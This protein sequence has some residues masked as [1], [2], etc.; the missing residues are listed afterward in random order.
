[1]LPKVCAWIRPTVITFTKIYWIL[2]MHSNVIIK[3]VSWPH[4]SW[5]TLY[6]D[7]PR[8]GV[9]YN[10][11][12]ICRLSVCMFVCQTFESLD[13]RSS[14]LHIR[15]ISREYGSSLY[16][17]VIGSRSRSQE[18]KRS[19]PPI[20][21]FDRP[22]LQFY[23][24]HGHEVCV[25]HGIFQYGGSNGVTA[26][27]SRDRKWPRVTKCTHSR[28]VSLR[29][30]GNLVIIINHYDIV[31]KVHIKVKKYEINIKRL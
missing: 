5:P 6:T 10:F 26:I 4:F 13:V 22:W 7:H 2:P 23:N 3:N 21:N 11:D 19:L 24:T 18:P 20:W 27:L 15:Y 28:V 31:P 16:M 29:L 25:Y 17:K 1:M 14:Y 12:R 8:S 30:E 9:G